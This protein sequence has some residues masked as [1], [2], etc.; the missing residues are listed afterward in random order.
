MQHGTLPLPKSVTPARIA[1]NL[2]VED[3]IISDADMAA[4]DALPAIGYSGH[5]PDEIRF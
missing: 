2:D 4:I 3:F 1:Q 5:H